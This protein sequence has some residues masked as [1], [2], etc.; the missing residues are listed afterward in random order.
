LLARAI[1][2]LDSNTTEARQ[3]L[4]ERARKA[5]AEQLEVRLSA[6]K[7]T[8][9]E[10]RA[11]ATAIDQVERAAAQKAQGPCA[12]LEAQ[13]TPDDVVALEAR[14]A[15][16]RGD[17]ATAV[18][19]FHP[20]ADQGRK[21]AETML[22]GLYLNAAEQGN[23]V[24][25]SILGYIYGTACSPPH[26]DEA[27]KWWHSAAN[28][29]EPHAQHHLGQ[30]YSKGYGVP[31]DYVQAFKYL[32]LASQKHS[33]VAGDSVEQLWALRLKMTDSELAQAVRLVKKWQPTA[34]A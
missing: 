6:E 22:G 29:G 11:L 15:L 27:L 30:A 18:K 12:D 21:F 19:L 5:M 32:T 2:A 10:Q 33:D 28:Q 8:L 7:E 23:V 16:E 4:Y 14:S 3:A 17:Y 1:S 26:Y 25:Q 9:L 20:L 34:D 31:L 24:A 13:S